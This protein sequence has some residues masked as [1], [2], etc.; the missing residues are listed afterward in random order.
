MH[1][2]RVASSVAPRIFSFVSHVYDLP[3]LQTLAYRRNHDLVIDELAAL[4]PDVVVDVGCGTGVLTERIARELRPTR[5][6]GCDASD[7]MLAKA[8]ERAVDVEWTLTRA[9][10][11]P[12]VDGSAD[13]VVCTEAFHF[14]D[15]PAALAEFRRVLRPGGTI[16]VVS[17]LTARGQMNRLVADA[18]LDL[19]DQRVARRL[20]GLPGSLATIA[21]RPAA[22]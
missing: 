19:V 11:L 6:V 10:S 7:G 13:A 4:R 22:G 2:S 1:V 16:I 15:Q 12:L 14:F 18:G 5:L 3:V 9:E 8:R 17:V 21:R 20:P